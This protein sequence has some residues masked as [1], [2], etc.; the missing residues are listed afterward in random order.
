MHFFQ[1]IFTTELVERFFTAS[2]GATAVDINGD[3]DEAE[4]GDGND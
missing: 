1:L 2:T 4:N 3:S